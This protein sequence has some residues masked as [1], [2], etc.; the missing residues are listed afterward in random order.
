MYVVYAVDTH[1]DNL[2]HGRYTVCERCIKPFI[3]AQNNF[4][5]EMSNSYMVKRDAV[6]FMNY[7][8]CRN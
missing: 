4:L 6:G 3:V 5:C 1:D 7:V 8:L 2:I